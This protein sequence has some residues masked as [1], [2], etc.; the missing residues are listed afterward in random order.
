MSTALLIV[1]AIKQAHNF[2]GGFEFHKRACESLPELRLPLLTRPNFIARIVLSAR[3]SVL[4]LSLVEHWDAPD[5]NQFQSYFRPSDA[6]LHAAYNRVPKGH[7]RSKQKSSARHEDSMELASHVVNR[8]SADLKLAVERDQ[9]PVELCRLDQR[10]TT[11]PCR[12]PFIK[13]I[14]DLLP[15][16]T[17]R[18]HRLLA[19][20][21]ET[22]FV[23]ALRHWPFTAPALLVELGQLVLSTPM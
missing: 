22:H 2:C 17:V 7:L 1:E 23:C 8:G 15:R 13:W 16:R 9:R 5:A 11:I 10:V 3:S 4:L 6:V 21:V 14:D 12:Q 18:T 19:V 20:N